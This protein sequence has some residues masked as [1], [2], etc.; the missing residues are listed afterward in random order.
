MSEAG[1]NE[2]ESFIHGEVKGDLRIP[3]GEQL[4]HGF[5]TK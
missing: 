4:N 2:L 3:Q 1:G 5:C